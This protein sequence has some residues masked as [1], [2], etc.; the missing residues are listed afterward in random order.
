MNA[1]QNTE[2]LEELLAQQATEGLEA[3]ERVELD[4]LLSE[5][6]EADGGAFDLAAAAIELAYLEVDEPLPGELR[7]QIES[8]AQHFFAGHPPGAATPGEER[9]AESNVHPFP[10]ERATA[11]APQRWGWLAAAA[12]LLLA[13]AGWWPRVATGPAEGPAE[14]PPAVAEAPPPPLPPTPAEERS[15]LLAEAGDSLEIEWAATE[16]PDAQGAGGDVVWS[17]TRQAGYMR[18]EGL[19]TNDPTE[20][21]YQLWIFDEERD[22]RYPVDGGVFDVP[23]SG[24]VVVPIRAKLPVDEP[25]LF[26]ITLEPPGGVV[27]SSRE[28]L[29]LVAPVG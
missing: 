7:S 20:A 18:F 28:R 24:E 10:A 26:A 15:E 4:A 2:R 1:P 11:P 23:P 9:A 27:V 12:C 19:P 17:N 8:S 29:L 25:T 3:A 5:H 13:L 14:A 22:E 21:Q 6:P 16:D